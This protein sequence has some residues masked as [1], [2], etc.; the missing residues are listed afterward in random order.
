MAKNPEPY[1]KRHL[2]GIIQCLLALYCS[3][4]ATLAYFFPRQASVGTS[5]PTGGSMSATYSMPWYLWIGIVG[6]SLS[7]AIPAV[8]GWIRK[9]RRN[10]E[11]VIPPPP[12]LV[13]DSATYGAIEGGGIDYPV[14]EF[15][16]Q[17]AGANGLAFEIQ[18]ANFQVNGW[19]Y[20][21]ID[22]K[23]YKKKRLKLTYS[24]AGGPSHTIR[25]REGG[26]LVLPEDSY[27][28]GFPLLRLDVIN[29]WNK[30]QIFF[31]DHKKRILDG[32]V[33]DENRTAKLL[34][35]A[36][37]PDTYLTVDYDQSLK[38]EMVDIYQRL[39]IYGV[40]DLQLAP[41]IRTLERPL[42][43]ATCPNDIENMIGIF[44][45]I[46]PKITEEDDEKK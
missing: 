7:V 8:I 30:L 25:R 46:A 33:S 4:I 18:N 35:F 14:E 42:F 24:Y 36:K 13:I 41:F 17:V 39:T 3:V 15:L 45:Q 19:N 12:K 27:I 2:P 1:W 22:P 23:E 29:A 28:E 5:A 20:V 16:N 44:W 31:N 37:S 9:E 34:Y 10:K 40:R 21:P 43:N 32:C 38:S 11:T 6:L 26:R